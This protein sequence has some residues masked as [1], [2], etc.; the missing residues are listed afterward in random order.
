M[1]NAVTQEQ[2]V[3]NS[4]LS[5]EQNVDTIGTVNADE[6]YDSSC[7]Q[8]EFVMNIERLRKMNVFVLDYT[9]PK[10]CVGY[11]RGHTALDKKRIWNIIKDVGFDNVVIAKL[12]DSHSVGDEIAAHIN[13][14]GNRVK[15][16]S[17]YCIVELYQSVE[18]GV[19]SFL[20]PPGITKMPKYGFSHIIVDFNIYDPFIDW[21]KFSFQDFHDLLTLRLEQIRSISRNGK[22]LLCCRDA[23]D[24][25]KSVKNR[26][27][28]LSFFAHVSTFLAPK[29]HIFGLMIEDAAG[30]LMPWEMATVIS[31][32]RGTMDSNGWENG[33]LLVQVGKGYGMA[34]MSTLAALSEGATGIWCS[35]CEEGGISG[36]ASSASILTNLFRLGNPFITSK[37]HI[38][39]LCSAAAKVSKIVT[40]TSVSLRQE[41]YGP[42]CTAALKYGKSRKILGDFEEDLGMAELEDEAD[43]RNDPLLAMVPD[44]SELLEQLE[45]TFEPK[46]Y[47]LKVVSNMRRVLLLDTKNKR[48]CDYYS[49]IGL[50]NLYENAGGDEYLQEMAEVIIN[51]ETFVEFD[52]HSLLLQLYAYFAAL[53][54]S[55]FLSEIF[56]QEKNS[57][58]CSKYGS[59][60]DESDVVTTRTLNPMLGHSLAEED[61]SISYQCFFDGFLS[62]FLAHAATRQFKELVGLLDYEKTGMIPWSQ[63]KLRARWALAEHPLER[64][65]WSLEEFI[66]IIVTSFLLTELNRK[67]RHLLFAK[68]PLAKICTM[69][70]KFD[71]TPE[72]V[73]RSM[74]LGSLFGAEFS[75]IVQGIE[76]EDCENS[77]LDHGPLANINDDENSGE[78]ERGTILS[79]GTEFRPLVG[80]F[81][82]DKDASAAFT[83]PLDHPALHARI[84][85][86]GAERSEESS[87]TKKLNVFS[88]ATRSGENILNR[89]RS[90]V[91]AAQDAIA[92]AGVT[93]QLT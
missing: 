9:I 56:F 29:Y 20:T 85:S 91:R 81:G 28:V 48:K 71:D 52:D 17:N 45:L 55:K 76:T 90:S 5:T 68:L 40:G 39:K 18:D 33:H 58:D 36:H 59:S 46:N 88:L 57:R 42:R 50:F 60:D 66:H 47:D 19:P 74:S 65:G 77:F 41:V 27:K 32:F 38:G 49:S 61:I 44:D 86:F 1:G 34:E 62:N 4:F 15:K 12:R 21:R 87:L 16:Q 13:L 64:D 92:L 69:V 70:P 82:P 54:D 89:R 7:L 80:D 24:I 25:F 23:F 8:Q 3:E 22:I 79:D 14:M 73:E 37:F 51:D 67:N 43:Y 30:S 53:G 6:I 75:D 31:A 63:I 84:D 83:S 2:Q 11:S 10:S 78:T 93:A 26:T 35:I 72:C